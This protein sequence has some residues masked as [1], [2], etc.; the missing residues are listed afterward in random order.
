MIS[1]TSFQI[2]ISRS[3]FAGESG[4]EARKWHT[5]IRRGCDLDVT[6]RPAGLRKTKTINVNK[7]EWREVL[8]KKKRMEDN[9]GRTEGTYYL[10]SRAGMIQAS[11]TAGKNEK[12]RRK[13]RM[14]GTA[15]VRK[16]RY[17]NG[18]DDCSCETKDENR[19][20]QCE[21]LNEFRYTVKAD[22]AFVYT[23]R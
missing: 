13:K 18:D 17:K 21:R 15:R 3:Q 16:M 1:R 23:E 4:R 19:H 12:N 14:R 8:R 7:S 6:R 9:K 11:G 5:F 20:A 10:V 2:S 22:G